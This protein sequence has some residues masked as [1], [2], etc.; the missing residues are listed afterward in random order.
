MKYPAPQEKGQP[1]K[2][3]GEKEHIGI[4]LV[5]TNIRFRCGRKKLSLAA[6]NVVIVRH[7]IEKETLFPEKLKKINKML[8]NA[9]LMD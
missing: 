9:E 4:Y 2:K 7:T 1:G 3:Y 5:Y 6:S 8:E